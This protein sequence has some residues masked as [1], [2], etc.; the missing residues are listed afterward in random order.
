MT[1]I[2]STPAEASDSAPAPAPTSAPTP[3]CANQR[4]HG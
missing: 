3:I 2:R 1:T 4:A